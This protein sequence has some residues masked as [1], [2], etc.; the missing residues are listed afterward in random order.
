MNN[1]PKKESPYNSNPFRFSDQHKAILVL[2][3]S[4]IALAVFVYGFITWTA[5]TSLYD[6]KLS[7]G[8]GE[9]KGLENYVDLFVGL[10]YERFRTDM[11]NA[12]FFTVL[13]IVVCLG[14]GLLLAILLDQKI[15]GEGVFRTI[16]LFP[17]ALSFIVT[18]VVWKWLFNPNNGLNTL[19]TIIGAPPGR[20]EWFISKDQWFTFNWQDLGTY[21]S[22]GILVIDVV[23][24]GLLVRWYRRRDQISGYAVAALLFLNTYLLLQGPQAMTALKRPETHGFNLALI[25]LVIAAGWQMSGYTMAMYLAGLRGIPDDLREAARVDGATEWGVYRHVVL[26]LM[27]PI[28]LSAMIVLGH[29]SL[30]IFDLVYGMG[31]GDN[32]Y[33]DMPGVNMFF[34][35]FRGGALGR[36][37]AIA[38]ILLIMVA[39]IIVPY[40]RSSLRAETEQ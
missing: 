26:P 22:G 7:T 15:A 34:T 16:Y 9:F 12:V 35:S 13:F 36:G 10:R 17:M 28:T 33:I 5:V 23:L 31:G 8:M 14:L 27:A 30:K 39:V 21:I 32:P 11:I 37:A 25:A 40:L 4:I 2:I 29:I 6:A 18:A 24:V 38:M 3:P 1:A 19:P 20:F